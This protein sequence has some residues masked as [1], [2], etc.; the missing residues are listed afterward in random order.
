MPANASTLSRRTD[1]RLVA[2][3][4]AAA[5]RRRR[6][7]RQ[8]KGSKAVIQT[9]EGD[10]ID[11]DLTEAPAASFEPENIPLDIVFEDEYLAVINKP[12]G[13]VVHPG[14]GIQ[15]ARWRMRSPGISAQAA[16]LLTKEGWQPLRL[17]GWFSTSN[18][19]Q[20]KQGL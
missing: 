1:R 17:T 19:S 18:R 9:P 5:D 20:L 3:A 12:A 16:P 15:S 6:C 10:E 13:M 2:L 11:I 14:A 4:A 8:R 7:S